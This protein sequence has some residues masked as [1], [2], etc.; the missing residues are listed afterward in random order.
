MRV[1]TLF[2]SLLLL[3]ALPSLSVAA[4][5]VEAPLWEVTVPGEVKDL[6]LNA[7][8][9]G[10]AVLSERTLSWYNRDGTPGWEIPANNAETIGVSEDGS[11]LVSGGADLRA[12]D[13]DGGRAF[14]F[15]T[16]F[17]AFG[18]GVSPEGSCIAAGFDNK[19]LTVFRTD[20]TD[21]FEPAWTVETTEDVISVAL[22]ENGTD[23]TACTKDGM[24]HSYT[25]DGRLLWSYDTG[26]EGLNCAVTRD[27]SYVVAGADHGVVLLLN[28]NGVLVREEVVGERLPSVSISAD[29]SV[30]AVGGDDGVVLRSL[31]GEDLGT[32]GTGKVHAVALSADGNRVAAAGP[33]GHLALFSIG[34]DEVVPGTTAA[35]STTAAASGSTGK[36]PVPAPTQ[37]AALSALPALAAVA[38]L[39]WGRR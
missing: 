9:T 19:S 38:F 39:L 8:G 6:A 30:V 25:G 1:P 5:P 21:D 32:L 15:D 28:R 16:G 36:E 35:T 37:Q 26:S 3:S 17:F 10:V 27:G 2:F 20:I 24:V 33:G 18:T 13:R 12:Y 7:D 11:L 31:Q 29:G 34:A 23:L 14:R 22:A 4:A